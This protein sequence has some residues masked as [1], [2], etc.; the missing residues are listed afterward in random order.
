VNDQSI[1]T[2]VALKA[3]GFVEDKSISSDDPGGLSFNF[4]N[5]TLQ[6]SHC[7]NLRFARVV[8]FSGVMSTPRTISQVSCEM[9]QRAESMEQVAAWV[10]HCLDKQ[11]GGKFHPSVPIAW[12]ET[13]RQNQ[14]LLPWN[15]SRGISA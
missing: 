9:P 15:C 3:L 4:G 12:L 6:A 11:S 2:Y 8:L 13:G 10:A 5:L 7:M 1:A 14:H